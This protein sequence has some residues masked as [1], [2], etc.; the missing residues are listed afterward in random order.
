MEKHLP[1]APAW[2]EMTIVLVCVE[3]IGHEI[4]QK[5]GEA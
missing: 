5:G 2:H 4:F 3:P 1:C